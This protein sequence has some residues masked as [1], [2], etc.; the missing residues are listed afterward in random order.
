MAGGLCLTSVKRAASP[1]ETM[2][3]R[4]PRAERRSSVLTRAAAMV[5]ELPRAAWV[6]RFAHSGWPL[7]CSIVIHCIVLICCIA[8][9]RGAAPIPESRDY[10]LI[11]G[12]VNPI[13]A[14]G[15]STEMVTPLQQSLIPEMGDAPAE[16]VQP[17]NVTP[18]ENDTAISAI[19]ERSPSIPPTMEPPN[20][21][22]IGVG[23]ANLPAGSAQQNG[24]DTNGAARAP[25]KS[26]S[27]RPASFF[28]VSGNAKSVMFVCDASGSML[29]TNDAIASELQ[30]AVVA[31]HPIQQFNVMFFSGLN[32]APKQFDV[33]PYVQANAANKL[34]ACEFA[35]RYHCK[36]R[37]HAMP[38]LRLALLRKP[39]V[40]YLLS[41]GDLD[42]HEDVM[43]LVGEINSDKSTRI[44]VIIISAFQPDSLPSYRALESISQMTG[45]VCR[46]I[47]P[48]N[49]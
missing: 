14:V 15:A 10:V 30:K 3:H 48:G 38:A 11:D 27:G 1:K 23:A 39:D 7:L 22:V 44:H 4:S 43:K 40:L 24:R 42:D 25:V 33:H 47:D 2:R 6:R 18:T 17:P 29:G 26:A 28:G 46:L 20:A 21:S 31:L 16:P 5:R 12:D 45:G 32:A 37:T 8:D 49:R 35:R 19:E 9:Y 34:A 36:G 13:A 41:D